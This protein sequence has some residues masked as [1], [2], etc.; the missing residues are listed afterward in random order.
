MQFNNNSTIL[1]IVDPDINYAQSNAFFGQKT[2]KSDSCGEVSICTPQF[3]RGDS[4][5]ARKEMIPEDN[6]TNE[7]MKH[8]RIM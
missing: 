5:F 8:F 2:T 1:K 3:R 4:N 6:S 7:N